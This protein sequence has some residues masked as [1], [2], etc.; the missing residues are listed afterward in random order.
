[1]Q[2]AHSFTLATA[3]AAAFTVA[4]PAFAQTPRPQETAGQKPAGREAQTLRASPPDTAPDEPE[5]G[6]RDNPGH[7][8][9]AADHGNVHGE[10]VAA[11]E[12]LA[13]AVERIDQHDRGL[14]LGGRHCPRL[15]GD[16]RHTRQQARQ[17]FHDDGM[18]GL[19]GRRNG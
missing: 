2:G 18:G 6:R 14:R 16:H 8:P 4:S 13:R 5:R 7:R 3:L 11:G 19:I 1:M 12:I 10:L 9:S 17:A 15:L